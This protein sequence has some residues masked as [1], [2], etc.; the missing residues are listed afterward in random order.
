MLIL[1]KKE[2][3]IYI[4]VSKK[5]YTFLNAKKF[6]QEELKGET[7]VTQAAALSIILIL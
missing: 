4:Y 2:K 5:N 7:E 1:G 3:Y 6:F